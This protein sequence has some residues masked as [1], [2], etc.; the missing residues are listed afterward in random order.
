MYSG[1]TVKLIGVVSIINPDTLPLEVVLPDAS[2][3]TAVTV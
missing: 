3:A 2:V 1:S